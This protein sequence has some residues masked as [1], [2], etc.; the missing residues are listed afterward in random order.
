MEEVYDIE[1]VVKA[2]HETKI[3][4]YYG[5]RYSIPTAEIIALPYNILFQKETRDSFSIN[6]KDQVIIIDE[7][8]NLIDMI[9]SMHSIE[10]SNTQIT[11]AASQLNAYYERYK[12]RLSAKNTLY[13]KLLLSVL[14][15]LNKCFSLKNDESEKNKL[16]TEN[17]K[18]S[19]SKYLYSQLFDTCQIE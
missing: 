18:L 2:G 12:S 13:C 4:P 1:D 9:S 6:L 19:M 3:C 10:I 11:Q 8:H 17:G 7:A 16:T 14:N 5:S 15:S